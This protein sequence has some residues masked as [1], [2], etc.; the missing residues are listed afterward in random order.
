MAP[1]AGFEPT[2][3][4]PKRHALPDLANR[5]IMVLHQGT[6]PRSFTYKVNALLLS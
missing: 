2:M 1:D 6:A 3:C 5:E 4:R